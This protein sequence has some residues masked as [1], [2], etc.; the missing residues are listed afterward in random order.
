MGH[1]DVDWGT[2]ICFPIAKMG[3]CVCV[4]PSVCLMGENISVCAAEWKVISKLEGGGGKEKGVFA[5]CGE[6]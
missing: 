1:R 2:A 3:G 5:P 4:C 6:G